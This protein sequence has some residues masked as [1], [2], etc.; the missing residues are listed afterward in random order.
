ME[1][2]EQGP[3]IEGCGFL[4]ITRRKSCL[5]RDHV[6]RH[7]LGAQVKLITRGGDRGL[8]ECLPKRV[9]SLLQEVASVLGVA[10]GPEERDEPV[11]A[12]RTR[13]REREEGQQCHPVPL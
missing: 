2:V 7:N 5:E 13:M 1:S 3:R 10:L 9:D 8:P 6:A 11:A 4:E 12:D